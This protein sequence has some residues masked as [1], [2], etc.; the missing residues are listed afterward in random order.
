MHYRTNK[1]LREI[2]IRIENKLKQHIESV[3]E[4]IKKKKK[5]KKKTVRI[6]ITRPG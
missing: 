2:T 1:A 5:K 6:R 3:T 4:E